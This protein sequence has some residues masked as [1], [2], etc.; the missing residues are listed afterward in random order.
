MLTLA[1]V[2]G[3]IINLS[4]QCLGL[5]PPFLAILTTFMLPLPLPKAAA[6]GMAT[7]IDVPCARRTAV[8]VTTT[9]I[10]P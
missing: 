6:S 8:V 1:V 2:H 9:S 7:V 5:L 4:Q 3:H 10:V